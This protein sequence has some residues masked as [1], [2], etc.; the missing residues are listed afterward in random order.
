V[1]FLEEQETRDMIRK[2]M[3]FVPMLI[4]LA[5]LCLHSVASSPPGSSVSARGVESPDQGLT[6]GIKV[7]YKTYQQ[8]EQQEDMFACLKLKA[9]KFADRAL[10]V[11]SI[12]LVDGMELVKKD[13]EEDGRQLNDPL[14]EV[15]EANLPTDPEKRQ[16]TLDDL[17]IDRLSRFLRSHTLQF[18]VPKFISNLGENTG[19]KMLEEGESVCPLPETPVGKLSS[20][21]F[22]RLQ[23]F[24]LH[25]TWDNIVTHKG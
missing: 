21:W 23:Y 13:D 11:K 2:L 10:K 7:L 4:S 14:V 22:C 20:Q 9:L 16:E 12:P 8:C 5:A 17:L 6:S 24:F 3:E 1:A 18:S 25:N 15:D 19:D